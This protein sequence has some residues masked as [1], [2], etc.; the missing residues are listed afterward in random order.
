MQKDLKGCEKGGFIVPPKFRAI[1][2]YPL[3][4]ENDASNR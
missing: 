1:K 2:D 4:K 3:Y